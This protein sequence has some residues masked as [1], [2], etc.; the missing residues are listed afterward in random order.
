[1][2][3]FLRD[4]WEIVKYRALGIILVVSLLFGCLVGL[5][6]YLAHTGDYEDSTVNVHLTTEAR[7]HSDWNEMPPPPGAS[8]GTRCWE[9]ST[10]VVC[11]FGTG[12]RP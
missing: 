1:M 10:G 3:E 6:W 12:A 5:G 7:T 2:R 11:D 4:A 9:R 8:E